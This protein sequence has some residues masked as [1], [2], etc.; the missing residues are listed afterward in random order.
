MNVVVIGGGLAAANAAGELREQG[1]TGDI[2]VVGG[3]PHPPYERPPLSKGLLLGSSEPDEAQ[4]HPREW[5]DEHQVDLREGTVATAIDLDR[6]RVQ[7]RS[8]EL[9]YD[10]LLLATG[11]TPRHLPMAD[12][13]GAP[14]LHLR[15]LD[16]ALAL[17]ERLSEGARIAIIGA[18]WIGLEVASAARQRGASVTVL[19]SA[20]LPLQRVLGDEIATVFADLHREHGVD[21]RLGVRVAGVENEHGE[22]V[23]HVEG[24]DPVVADLLVV[25]VGVSPTDELAA[26]A[27]LAV[28]NGILVDA[29]LRTPDPHVFAAGDVANHDHPTLGTHVRVEHWD[30]A[31]HHGSHAARVMLGSDEP[32]TRLPYFFTDQYDLGMEYV[33]HGAGYDDLVV[34]GDL[35]A[36]QASVLWLR[37][38]RVAAG[39][40]L[41]DWDAI[42]PLRAV[43]GRPATEAVRDPAVPLGDLM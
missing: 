22:A 19:E 9:P 41:N 43:V 23:V 24:A 13:S 30:T 25:A 34:R 37:E 28:D 27:G 39:M 16:D 20:P 26:R 8:G 32:Y 6:R 18:G 15:T 14:V 7:L 38:D 33:G 10:R 29:W 17:R 11:A 36:R 40:H 21:L 3:E 12:G 31:I 2:V 42:G 4:I 35:A 5:Y 1:H